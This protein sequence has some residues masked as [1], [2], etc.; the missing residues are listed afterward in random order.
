MIQFVGIIGDYHTWTEYKDDEREHNR[1]RS[2]LS[3]DGYN[4]RTY[5]EGDIGLWTFFFGKMFDACKKVGNNRG[6][7]EKV[8]AC[9]RISDDSK[10]A[11]H[12]TFYYIQENEGNLTYVIAQPDPITRK[13]KAV[14]RYTEPLI[15]TAAHIRKTAPKILE[16]IKKKETTH[17]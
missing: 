2:A 12:R 11:K 8:I 9:I 15:L 13:D 14:T 7:L 16:Y 3:L 5:L 17:V 1:R 4:I 10:D 6:R